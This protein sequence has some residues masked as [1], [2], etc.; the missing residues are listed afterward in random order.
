MRHLNKLALAAF[1]GLHLLFLSDLALAQPRPMAEDVFT[2]IAQG[3]DLMREGKYQAAQYEFETALKR[4]RYNPFALNNLAAL[5]EQ[6]GHLQEA[7]AFL[8]DAQANAKDYHDKVEQTCFTGGLCAG[9]KPVKAVGPTSTIA[10]IIDEN[11]KR[12]QDKMAK[13]PLP[14]EL[15]TPSAPA[16]GKN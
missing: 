16:P 13:S 5:K 12:L 2:P 9:V 14:P 8:V 1:F 4:D 11:L 15:S 3:Y 6:Q 10:G 7:L